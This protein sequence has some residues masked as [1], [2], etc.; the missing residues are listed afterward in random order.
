MS[1]ATLTRNWQVNLISHTHWDRAWY[2]TFQEYRMR[3]V[4]L[5]DRLLEILKNDPDYCYYML[6]GQMSVLDDYFEVRPQRKVELQAL[7]RS[8]RVQVGPW[9]VLA[10]EFLVSPESLIRN[11]MLGHRIGED[12][13]GVMK[14]GYVPDGFGHI[15]QLPQILRG[16]GIDNA[17]FWRGM[18][19]EGD[20][21]GTEFEWV[22]LDGSS[23][24]TIL[25]PW[26]YHTASNIGYGVHW[27]DFSQMAFNPDLAQEKLDK[28]IDKLTPMAHTDAI[29]L[30]N[31]IDH[32][33]AQPQIPSILAQANVRKKFHIEQTTLKKH[34]DRVRAY[35]Q[36]HAI[37]FP[38]FQG[39]FRWGCY[40]EILQGIHATRLHLKQ[41]NHQIETLLERVMEPLVAIAALAGATTVEQQAGTDDLVWTAWRWLLLNHPHDDMYGCGIDAVHEEMA[42][43]F[44]QAEQIAT[45][46]SRDNLRA[47]TRHVD[48]TGQGGIPVIFVNTLNWKRDEITEVDIDFDYDDSVADSFELVTPD[49]FPVP[50]QLLSDEQTFWME[51]LKAN[52]KR[53]VRILVP[54][55]IPACGYT[56][57]YV[58][59]KRHPRI[60]ANDWAVETQAAENR[61]LRLKIER[62]GGLTVTHKASGKTYSG[63]NHFEDVADA[64]D[65]YTF[66]PIQGDTPLSTQGNPAEVRQLWVGTNAVAYEIT[67][68]L[69]LPTQI[70]EGRLTREGETNIT[71]TSTVTL[72]RDCPY[73]DVRTTFYN[74]A[75]DHKL[76]VV[77]PTDMTVQKAAVNE[78]FA[79]VDRSIDL[80]VSD[81]WV[82]D[83]TPLMHQRAFTDLSDG[84]NG[85]A[86]FNRGLAGVEV[87]RTAEGTRT[88]VPLVRSV[89]W[90]S[91][92]DLWVRR[93]AAGPLVPT[94]GAQCI[95]ERTA[96]Y[97]IFPHAGDWQSVYAQA[98]NYVTPIT[99]GRADTHAGIDLHDMN[100]TRDDPSKITYIPFPRE[101]E[102][103]DT[104]SFVQV[105]GD[106]IILSAL[107]RAK[108][109]ELL[110]RF[111]NI[112]REDT[113]ATIGSVKALVT[114]NQLNLNE[115]IECVL[116][117]DDAHRL[118]IAVRAG[119]I[120]TV[121]LTFGA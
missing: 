5:I 53:R 14:I 52:R 10:D 112:K 12:F 23:V 74:S 20:E 8:G 7:T 105:E 83:P 73:V 121:G 17:F 19:K 25:L 30:M 68:Q 51:T 50:H 91:R 86:I 1:S 27:G 84:Q 37:S 43:R 71:I 79:V 60:I 89:G 48:F 39:E 96:E 32:Q 4:Q 77:F 78:S 22:A 81:G 6:D 115:D 34:L 80:P 118:T 119:Q 103:P 93:I 3:L 110:V 61:Y 26:G 102:L 57:L 28:F 67:H 49:G 113:V 69:K 31:G 111:F 109:G 104:Y 87:T 101:G 11:L 38:S 45:F 21:L 99:A 55:S 62:D 41:R 36:T 65:A 90:L 76:S 108:S 95:G 35:A 40:S 33:E 54:V 75:R 58:Q 29:L 42:Y 70:S 63:L 100:I 2:V 82:E 13:G 66:C 56:T 94:P 107:R 47:L 117:I 44:C 24:T 97:A 116:Q 98:Y 15:A 46:L 59:P 120:V 18:G 92:D 64:G 9:F 85:L 16:F 88:A 114:A 72:K 106:G